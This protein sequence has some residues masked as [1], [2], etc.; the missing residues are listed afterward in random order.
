MAPRYVRDADG[1]ECSRIISSMPR[2]STSYGASQPVWTMGR[3]PEARRSGSVR[4]SQASSRSLSAEPSTRRASRLSE[5]F[6]G[7]YS[8]AQASW[9]RRTMSTADSDDDGPQLAPR[10]LAMGE[11][12]GR[13]SQVSSVSSVMSERLEWLS[14][15]K[16]RQEPEH[17]SPSYYNVAEAYDACYKKNTPKLTFSRA[18]GMTRLEMEE[19]AIERSARAR[20]SAGSPM[21]QASG[22]KLRKSV[23]N[24]G[25]DERAPPVGRAREIAETIYNPDAMYNPGPTDF[26]CN[27][28]K[29]FGAKIDGRPWF[30]SKYSPAGL[31]AL[32]AARN[33]GRWKGEQ[34][35][36]STGRRLSSAS[37]ERPTSASRERPTSASRER[38]SS[39]QADRIP[40]T[41][42]GGRIKS[43]RQSAEAKSNSSSPRS[44]ASGASPKSTTPRSGSSKSTS[45]PRLEH[46]RDFEPPRVSA[47]GLSMTLSSSSM[48]G[49]ARRIRPVSAPLR[50][51]EGKGGGANRP[52]GIAARPDDRKARAG[53]PR[54]DGTFGEPP[55]LPRR[56]NTTSAAEARAKLKAQ[57]AARPKSARRKSAVRVE[58][59]RAV[60]P[61]GELLTEMHSE[62]T[63]Y[64]PQFYRND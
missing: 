56:S 27:A 50:R 14:Q 57:R 36:T 5:G 24:Q 18:R 31:E 7:G 29:P 19:A 49:N 52:V 58:N 42:S 15:P 60:K 9:M 55:A 44:P 41:S 6:G 38:L 21:N 37:R 64:V 34:R 51:G 25:R 22:S 17:A 61:V 63:M 40:V 2:S 3:D 46:S 32:H 35:S 8:P 11:N 28:H 48:D 33:S 12:G 10:R 62:G 26:E 1:R 13:L 20:M 30:Y 4:L 59:E 54:Q 23:G 39:A 53:D 16:R 43:V 47:T 45:S